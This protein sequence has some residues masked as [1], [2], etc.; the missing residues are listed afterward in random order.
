MQHRIRKFSAVIAAAA[1]LS[2]TAC[3]HGNNADNQQS[4]AGSYAPTANT[5]PAVTPSAPSYDGAP[6]TASVDTTTPTHHSKLG[7]ALVGAAAGHVLG[8]HALAGAAVGALV[9]HER[10]KHQK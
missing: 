10:N 8:H 3:G 7:G 2:V 4:A 9:Q 5:T 1:S 6:A